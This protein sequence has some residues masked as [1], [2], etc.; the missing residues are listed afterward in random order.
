MNVISLITDFGQND[1]FVG[2]IKGVI[3]SI[4]PNAKIVDI[5]HEVKPHDILTG[6]FLLKSSFKY[7]PKGSLH[8]VVVDPGVGSERKKLLVKTKD[9]FFVAPDNGVLSPALKD[10]VSSK[11]I[12]ITNKN[13]FLKPTSDTFHGRDIF[14]PTAAYLSKGE[15][16]SKFGKRIKSIKELRLP[17]VQMAAERLIGEVIYID[18]FGNLVSNI[19]KEILGRFI[20]NK[21]FKIFI[22][23]KTIDKL[24]H[25]YTEGTY[26]K[27]LALIDSFNYL[28]IALNR[29]SACN[30]LKAKKGTEVILAVT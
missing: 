5:C 24:S 17:Q 15:D 22:K 3:L 19:G 9:Y 6:A 8:L 1:N 10:Q 14:A 20:K 23:N 26:L 13:Y 7:F 12:E 28:E 18:R 21:K 16:F 30:Y 27:P 11:I 4:N 29:G 2:V 25:S